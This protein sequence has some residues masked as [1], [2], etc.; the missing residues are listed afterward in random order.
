MWTEE[1]K[2]IPLQGILNDKSREFK[3]IGTIDS[4]GMQEKDPIKWK[5]PESNS[6]HT[7]EKEEG[8]DKKKRKYG[9]AGMCTLYKC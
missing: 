4:Y 9:A 8:G 1:T 6:C 2:S 5:N 7:K 3:G